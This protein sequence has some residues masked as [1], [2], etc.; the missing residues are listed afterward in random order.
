MATGLQQRQHQRRELVAHRNRREAHA[1]VVAGA[2]DRE[3]RP[4]RILAV[5]AHADQRAQRRDLVEQF[6]HLARGFTL[7][8]RRDDLDRVRKSL[9]IRGKLGLEGVVQHGELRG[10]TK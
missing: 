5:M 10:E 8:E 4:A 2:A 7:V 3:R 9:Q 1:H 6:A